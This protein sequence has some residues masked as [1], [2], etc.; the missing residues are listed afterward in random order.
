MTNPL[1]RSSQ[2]VS[3]RAA[4]IGPDRKKERIIAA[5]MDI[6]AFAK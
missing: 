5:T 1:P 6:G 3:D 2:L 4:L